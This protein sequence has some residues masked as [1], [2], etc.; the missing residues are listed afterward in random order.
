MAPLRRTSGPDIDQV[1]SGLRGGAIS[2]FFFK[3]PVRCWCAPNWNEQSDVL[4]L[5]AGT[6]CHAPACI[7]ET[8][9]VVATG[10]VLCANRPLYGKGVDPAMDEVAYAVGIPPCYWGVEAKERLR[11][12]PRLSLDTELR[13]VKYNNNTFYHT[14]VMAQ[15]QMRGAWV[16]PA[17]G[18]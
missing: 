16:D 4:L 14:G 1:D 10:E 11:P 5:R 7:N 6:H 3:T 18:A 12:P 9:T 15:W 13:L 8:L 17:K 2:F